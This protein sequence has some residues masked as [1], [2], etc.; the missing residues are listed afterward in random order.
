MRYTYE[1]L[2]RQSEE[3]T[4]LRT[5]RLSRED[6]INMQRDLEQLSDYQLLNKGSVPCNSLIIMKSSEHVLC[7]GT[8]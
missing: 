6:N 1:I 3:K 2:V 4:P 8:V 5:H 7:T